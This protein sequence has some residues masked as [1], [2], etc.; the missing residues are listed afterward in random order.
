MLSILVFDNNKNVCMEIINMLSECEIS[1]KINIAFT[2]KDISKILSKHTINII[3][4]N[5]M[6]VGLLKEENSYN[7][8][9]II[10]F[11]LKDNI[12]NFRYNS[13]FHH[14]ESSSINE[15]LMK[16]DKQDKKKKNIIRDNVSKELE[17]LNYN[18]QRNTISY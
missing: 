10:C 4:I 5:N 13:T 16:I 12:Y 7:F 18:L 1:L 15:I 2:I 17:K 9:H 11:A 3:L 6:R 8:E 14:V